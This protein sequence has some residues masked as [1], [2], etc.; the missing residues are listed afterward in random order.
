MKETEEIGLNLS[1]LSRYFRKYKLCSSC[2]H[3]NHLK[4]TLKDESRFSV[5]VQSNAVRVLGDMSYSR[6]GVRCLATYWSLFR[7]GINSFSKKISTRSLSA[8]Q[9]DFS[10]VCFDFPGFSKSYC[11]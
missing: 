11:N 8:I 9:S 1:Y 3:W 2:G 7:H 10:V 5:H 4:S 6:S